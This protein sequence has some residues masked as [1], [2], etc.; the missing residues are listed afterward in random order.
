MQR[1]QEEYRKTGKSSSALE[2]HRELNALKGTKLPWMYEVSKCAPQEALRNLDAAFA[3]FFRWVRQKKAGK[4][5]GK[6][7][8]PKRKSKKKGLGGFRLMGTII[9]FPEVIQL[10]RLGRL[11]LKERGRIPTSGVK[12]LSAAVREQA[13]HWYVSVLVE[14]EHVV[15]E[16]SGPVVGVDLGIKRFATL[17]DGQI[18]ENPRYL[19]RSLRKIKHL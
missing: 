2:L 19:I 8:Y 17:S 11:R 6:L 18:E 3:H 9:V 5:K 4:Y 10:P 16:N 12:I 15:T 14:Q 7:G 1:K 13:S